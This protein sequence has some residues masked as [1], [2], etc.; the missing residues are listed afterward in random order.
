MCW[1]LMAIVLILLILRIRY[2]WQQALIILLPTL[3]AM[4][5]TI[6]LFGYLHIALTLFNMM[7]LMLMLGIGINYAI[8]LR[9]GG[10]NRAATL[11]GV[12]LSAGTTLLSFGMLAFSS[13]PALANFGLTLL[14][15]I[16]ISAML[17]PMLLSFEQQSGPTTPGNT[18]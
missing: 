14:C 3:L 13:M 2:S 9:E 18:A 1:L 8:F 5:L 10:I 17:A 6:G 15:G 12:L 16:A 4:I 11:A 7:S